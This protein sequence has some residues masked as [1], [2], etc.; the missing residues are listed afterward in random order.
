MG[1]AAATPKTEPAPAAAEPAALAASAEHRRAPRRRM[2]M[3]MKVYVSSANDP[4]VVDIWCEDI[5]I[6]GI[7]FTSRRLFQKGEQFAILLKL[8]NLPQKLV[9]AR[10]A[11]S[12]YAKAGMH[13]VGAEFLES[14]AAPSDELAI[15]R[16]WRLS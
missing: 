11:H 15:P 12:R 10:V 3:H 5:S 16:Q 7:G 1:E 14:V 8:G 9:L 2:R 4:G 13:T 6:S